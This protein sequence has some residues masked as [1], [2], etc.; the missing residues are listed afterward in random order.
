[1]FFDAGGNEVF[2]PEGYLRPFHLAAALD[3]VAAGAYV[4]EP[5]FQRFIQAARRWDARGGQAGRSVEMK[6]PLR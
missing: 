1:V 6:R 4:R 3:Y 5:S 2:R